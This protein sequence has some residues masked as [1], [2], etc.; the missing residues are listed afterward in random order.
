[1]GARAGVEKQYCIVERY[2]WRQTM[3]RVGS[4]VEQ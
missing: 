2:A 1:M 4:E 3:L